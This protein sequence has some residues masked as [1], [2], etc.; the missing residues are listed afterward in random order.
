[1]SDSDLLARLDLLQQVLG[2]K[3][4]LRDPSEL[5]DEEEPPAPGI[6]SGENSNWEQWQ[7]KEDTATQTSN[8]WNQESPARREAQP[9]PGLDQEVLS[10]NAGFDCSSLRVGEVL[11]KEVTFSPWQTIL[12]YP[13]N[14][15][16]KVNKPRARPF[17]DKILEGNAWDIFYLHDPAKPKEPPHLL[18]PTDQFEDF[19]TG[20]NK[21]L[22]TALEIPPGVNRRRFCLRFGKGGTPQPRYLLRAKDT[23]ALEISSW[24][25][26]SESDVEGFN[27][28]PKMRQDGFVHALATINQ[29][30]DNSDRSQKAQEKANQRA[31]DRQLMMRQ[32]QEYLGLRQGGISRRVVFVCMD[33]EAVEVAPHPVSEVGIAILDADDI[34]DVPPGPSGSNWWQFVKAYHLRTKEYS[35]LVNYRY[36]QGCPGAF[37]FGASS[38]STFPAKKE[39]ADAVRST[40]Q[41]YTD[42]HHDVVFV[43]H[44]TKA[45]VTYLSN[46]GFE[47]LDMPGML[48]D[49]DT[50]LLHQAWRK[51]SDGRSLGTIL[52][53]LCIANEHLH[54]AGND[55][56]YTLRA[57]MGLA[58][59]QLRKDEADA[60]GEEYVPALWAESG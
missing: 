52:S 16:G 40:L 56:V 45:D 1:M 17:F 29:S 34:R 30:K 57:M 60:K 24:P 18:V 12:A 35:G 20:V 23:N 55:A 51:S 13:N 3:V 19:L 53:D 28:A 22:N 49:I 25:E 10:I 33:V 14:F 21:A 44:D 54:N 47:V 9:I 38:T 2:K 15:I 46:I 6:M 7:T 5:S 50:V 42:G 41:P 37:D 4:T 48:G 58:V 32:A 26:I 27:R 11:S 31:L 8:A 43:A 59:E 36:V 39:L